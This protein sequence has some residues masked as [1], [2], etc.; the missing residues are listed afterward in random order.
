M[1]IECS[2]VLLP[3]RFCYL[4]AVIIPC[5]H[6]VQF[7]NI[8]NCRISR[9]AKARNIIG[10]GCIGI[11][12]EIHDTVFIFVVVIRYIRPFSIH[13]FQIADFVVAASAGKDPFDLSVHFLRIKVRTFGMQI[14]IGRF[15][16][17]VD[18]ILT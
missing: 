16:F 3:Y 8:R 1:E 14:G 2:I 4:I 6:P 17:P 10:H 12:S 9:R 15:L 11:P 7:D 13:L 5:I 18:H